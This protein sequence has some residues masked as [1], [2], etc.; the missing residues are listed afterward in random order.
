MKCSLRTRTKCRVFLEKTAN[1]AD[2]FAPQQYVFEL[3]CYS[4]SK[5]CIPALYLPF[6]CRIVASVHLSMVPYG[7]TASMILAEHLTSFEH[8]SIAIQSSRGFYRSHYLTMASDC[9][10]ADTS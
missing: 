3:K 6:D 4:E 2:E 10:A 7:Y 1:V 5:A 8:V 9:L